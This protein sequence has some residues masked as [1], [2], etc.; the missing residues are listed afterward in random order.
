MVTGTESV[1]IM[2]ANLRDDA[3]FA[4]ADDKLR[5]L[6]V[7]AGELRRHLDRVQAAEERPAQYNLDREAEALIEGKPFACVDRSREEENLRRDIR[8]TERALRLQGEAVERERMRVSKTVCGAAVPG[9]RRA[10]ARVA[11]ALESLTNALVEVEAIQ[12]GLHDRGFL[13]GVEP[14]LRP[15]PA[16]FGRLDVRYSRASQWMCEAIENDLIPS[17]VGGR[18]EL[19]ISLLLARR[20]HPRA[21]AN[22]KY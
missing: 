19:E 10:L 1:D 5:A 18:N 8:V 4:A 2:K 15:M 20:W 22:P 11:D 12:Q 21:Q 6:Q 13:T 7:W 16:P 14:K 9:Y 17:D 3:G